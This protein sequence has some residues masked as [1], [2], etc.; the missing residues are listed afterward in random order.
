MAILS[1]ITH[2]IQGEF[3]NR[4]FGSFFLALIS[5]YT[6]VFEVKRT[7]DDLKLAGMDFQAW[8]ANIILGSNL[9]SEF[10]SGR[11]QGQQH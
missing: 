4:G 7:L 2:I 6:P 8:M 3:R 5:E 11:Y 10:F 1:S 9:G